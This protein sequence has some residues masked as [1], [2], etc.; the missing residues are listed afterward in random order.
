MD[1]QN[2][3]TLGLQKKSRKGLAKQN[4]GTTSN[5]AEH[6]IK[7]YGMKL[8]WWRFD[9]FHRIISS[10]QQISSKITNQCRH[11]LHCRRKNI[12]TQQRSV[13][14]AMPSNPQSPHP[15]PPFQRKEAQLSPTNLYQPFSPP[16]IK[17][18]LPFNNL[19]CKSGVPSFALTTSLARCRSLGFD[20]PEISARFDRGLGRGKV[21][22]L[23][24][25]SKVAGSDIDIDI[26]T[27]MW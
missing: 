26:Q 2:L 23:N 21:L 20:A 8:N 16:A 25:S 10:T 4:S 11:C 14:L 6:A 5:T 19:S 15:P 24:R 18:P 1:N 9:G 17:E 12:A 7:V 22:I 3:R 27:W 13:L